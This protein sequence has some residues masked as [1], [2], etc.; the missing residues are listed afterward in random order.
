ML[1]LRRHLGSNQSYT[2]ITSPKF[3]CVFNLD[4]NVLSEQL[5]GMTVITE[6]QAAGA[7]HRK[8]RSVKRILACRARE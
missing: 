7:E 5:V 1:R 8:V 6:F 4:L 2:S 3:P